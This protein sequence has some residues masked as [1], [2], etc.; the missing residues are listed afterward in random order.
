MLVLRKRQG[1]GDRG[2]MGPEC[3]VA[4]GVVEKP[5]AQQ[6]EGFQSERAEVALLSQVWAEGQE[7][8]HREGNPGPGRRAC[9][10]LA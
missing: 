1:F 10:H 9:S 8:R 3:E 2:A 4:G 6:S 5:Q 7:E